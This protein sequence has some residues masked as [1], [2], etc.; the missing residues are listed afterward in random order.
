MVGLLHE[1]R[2]WLY[3]VVLMLYNHCVGVYHW[4]YTVY[5]FFNCILVHII[6]GSVCSF[7]W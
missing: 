3:M 4:H 2:W 5:T 7:L 6:V 1:T